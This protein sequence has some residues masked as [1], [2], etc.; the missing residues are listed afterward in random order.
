MQMPSAVAFWLAAPGK[1]EYSCSAAETSIDR[2]QPA[3]AP[4][5]L[6]SMLTLQLLLALGKAC[7]TLCLGSNFCLLGHHRELEGQLRTREPY[8][9]Q[10]MLG[11]PVLPEPHAAA[12]QV[13][14]QSSAPASSVAHPRRQLLLPISG[15]AG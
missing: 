6:R 5:K 15:D 2:R 3:V 9:K 7:S 11:M 4:C 14:Y 10:S 13:V 12:W 8:A 1:S